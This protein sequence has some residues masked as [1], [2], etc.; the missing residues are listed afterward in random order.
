MSLAEVTG[1]KRVGE[2]VSNDATESFGSL[3]PVETPV[4]SIWMA[5]L[6]NSS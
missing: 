2:F 6:L 4:T 5:N 1:S 3:S